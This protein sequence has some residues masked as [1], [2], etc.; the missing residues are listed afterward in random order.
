M[1]KSETLAEKLS[2]EEKWITVRRGLALL[3]GV[4]L[5]GAMDRYGAEAAEAAGKAWREARLK[6]APAMAEKLGVKEK[7]CRGVAAL[8]N[9]ADHLYGVEGEWSEFTPQKAVKE[10][11]KCDIAELLPDEVCTVCFREAVTGIGLSLTGNPKFTCTIE[12]PAGD[13]VCK[14]T[15][16]NPK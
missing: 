16:N 3:V 12:R 8:M 6:G 13:L 11:T 4:T 15:I 2:V 5:K 9:Y 1:V 14:I 7:D 10:V